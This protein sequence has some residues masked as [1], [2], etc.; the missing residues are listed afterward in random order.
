MVAPF[1][2][3]LLVVLLLLLLTG[4]DR[5]IVD[6]RGY[7]GASLGRRRRT[8]SC[9]LSIGSRQDRFLAE[10]H[11]ECKPLKIALYLKF[12]GVLTCNLAI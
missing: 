5:D 4:L 2:L 3:L 6:G 7:V 1:P 11:S 8:R 10:T 9:R 12:L